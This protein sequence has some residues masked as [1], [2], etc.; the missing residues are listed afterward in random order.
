MTTY[1]ERIKIL[2]KIDRRKVIAGVGLLGGLILLLYGLM[3]TRLYY[4]IP[5][6]STVFRYIHGIVTI[7]WAFMA[8]SS[9][10]LLLRG[11]KVGYIILLLAG[12]GGLVGSFIPIFAYDPYGYGYIQVIYLNGTAYIDIV[13]MLLGGIY[14]VALTEKKE[15]RIK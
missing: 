4:S 11:N 8:I 12:I 7:V 6:E 14:G 15:T 9:S 13:L 5:D 1:N 10:V 2:P 3:S